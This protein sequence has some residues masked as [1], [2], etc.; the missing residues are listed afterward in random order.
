MQTLNLDVEDGM[1]IDINLIVVFDVF[2]EFL[3]VLEFDLVHL[4][5]DRFIIRVFFKGF[6]LGH[7]FDPFIADLGR[8]E[9]SEFWIG[10]DEPSSMSDTIG[11]VIE[12]LWHIRIEFFE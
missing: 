2:G 9:F 6:D 1:H 5:E 3:L 7:I 10:V 8:D 12:L 11:L 4:F